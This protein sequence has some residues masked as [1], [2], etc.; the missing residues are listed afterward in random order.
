MSHHN[1]GIC[2]IIV[3]SLTPASL[4]AAIC[5]PTISINIVA[6]ALKCIDSLFQPGHRV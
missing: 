3:G 2:M 6:M 5:G 1:G 4:E